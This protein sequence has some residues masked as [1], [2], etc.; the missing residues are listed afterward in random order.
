MSAPAQSLVLKLGGSLSETGRLGDLAALV[1]RAT[2]NVVV[3]PGGGAFA[4]TVR[5]IEPALNIPQALSHRLALL[6]MHQ[7]GLVIE[8]KSPRYHAAETLEDIAGELVLG[9]VPVWMPFAMQHDDPTL[10]ADWRT[11]SDALAARLAERLGGAVVALV[12]SCE[13]PTGSTLDSLTRAGIVDPM[14]GEVVARAGLTWAVYGP[15]DEAALQARLGLER[16]DGHR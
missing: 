3:V 15:G 1:S 2:V 6:A 12:K 9:A 5:M 7:M 4:D 10:P 8:S 14:F 16:T 11:T 13:I